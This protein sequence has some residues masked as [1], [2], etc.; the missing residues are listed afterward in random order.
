MRSS[1]GSADPW[2]S[3]LVPSDS[4]PGATRAPT[5]FTG[6]ARHDPETRE[7]S[8]DSR[9]VLGYLA[10]RPPTPLDEVGEH[11]GL[12]LLEVAEAVK[13]LTSRGLVRVRTVGGQ[14]QVQAVDGAAREADG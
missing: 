10:D 7:L 3:F 4:P 1:S 5:G 11:V 8:P 9:E 13:Q 14:E 6:P 12:G 2:S